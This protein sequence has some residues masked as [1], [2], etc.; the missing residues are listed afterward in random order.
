MPYDQLVIAC[1]VQTNTFGITSIDEYLNDEVFFLKQLQHSRALRMNIIAQLEKAS[2]PNIGVDEQKRL[3]SFVVVGGGPTS[4][5]FTAEL[6][7]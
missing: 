1:G 6:H 2:L 3:L 4:C 5:E 7:G